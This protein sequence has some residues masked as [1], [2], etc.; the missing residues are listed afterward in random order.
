[1]TITPETLVTVLHYSRETQMNHIL[2]IEP[3]DLE[4]AG[5]QGV[6]NALIDKTR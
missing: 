1:M 2:E 6:G 3:T 4:V 5:A